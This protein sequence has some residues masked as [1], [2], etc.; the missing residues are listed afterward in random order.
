MVSIRIKKM[1]IEYVQEKG[2]A[3]THEILEHINMNTKEGTS[4]QTLNNVLGKNP[5]FVKVE[6]KRCYDRGRRWKESIWQVTN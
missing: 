2:N 6:T 4:I 3:S 5:E 1:A